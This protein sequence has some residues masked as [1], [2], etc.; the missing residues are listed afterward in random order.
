MHGEQN[1]KL[2]FYQ[3]ICNTLKMGTRSVPETS[4]NLHI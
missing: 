2:W 3:A 4:E 1:I